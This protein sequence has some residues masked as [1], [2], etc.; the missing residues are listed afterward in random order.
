MPAQPSPPQEQIDNLISLY[1]S[2]RINEAAQA[3]TELLQIFPQ[4]AILHNIY[5]SVLTSLGRR[6]QA[7][8]EINM[9]IRFQPDYAAAYNNLGNALAAAGKHD[10]ANRGNSFQQLGSFYK[11]VKDFD[12]A[13]ELKPDYAEAYNYRSRA[14][15]IMG[16]LREAIESSDRAIQLKPGD[17]DAYI[18]RGDALQ[19]LGLFDEACVAYRQA[20]AITPDNKGAISGLLCTLNY[21]PS[22]SQKEIYNEHV[23]YRSVFEQGG[24][25]QN[26]DYREKPVHQRL[27]I[28]YVS[29][30]FRSH[31]VANF[32]EPLI[33]YHNRNAFEIYCYSNNI[34][35]DN[36]TRR[37]MELADHWR[38]IANVDDD[39]VVAMIKQDEIDI[40]VDLCGHT[41]KNRLSVFARKPAPVQVSWLGYPNTTGLST[42]D[43]RLTDAIAD[44]V[45]EA[46]SLH[47]ERLIRLEK[48]FLCYQGDDSAH[49]ADSPPCSQRRYITYGCFNKL[50]KITPI[51]IRLW[52]KILRAVPGSRLLLKS[53]QLAEPELRSRYLEMFRQASIAEERIELHS[54]LPEKRDH[55]Q[56]YNSVDIALDTF[57]YNGTTTTC[58][59]LWMGVPVITLSGDRHAGRVGASI[60]THAG[61]RECIATNP[62]EY[63]S[64]AIS[65]AKRTD[66]LLELKR[67]LRSRILA[68]DLCN[69]S[70]FTE[71]IEAVYCQI[72]DLQV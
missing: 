42:I 49:S 70:G 22:L 53:A 38:P 37:F 45:G 72:R 33:K 21:M 63:V 51:A 32:L 18:R 62:D 27:R 7:I 44:P 54:W 43:Y 34:I 23:H 41:W 57:P 5:G 59:A 66:Y 14:F 3:C 6:E 13:I 61:L 15:G 52:A 58:E 1:T 35:S 40:L 29:P 65:C 17:A 30:D 10:Y 39:D 55:L 9:A 36:I 2:N 25:Q 24:Y 71:T 12:T 67:D 46:D 47:S 56:L 69:A 16:R 64:L 28:G 11:A 8:D 60:M 20:I 50:I 31:S 4:S 19:G 26:T 48:G 68:S